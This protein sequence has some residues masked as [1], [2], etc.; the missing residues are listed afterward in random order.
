MLNTSTGMALGDS[1]DAYGRHWERNIKKTLEDFENEKPVDIEIGDAT[2][3]EEIQYTISIFH[4][5]TNGLE[6]DEVCNTF[7]ALPCDDWDSEIYGVSTNQAEWLKNQGFEVKE[8]WNSYNGE[9]SLSQVIQ[10]TYVKR[11]TDLYV[12]LQVHQGCDIRGGYT[13][14]KMFY[15]PEGYMPSENVIGD[16]DGAMIDNMYNGTSLTGEGGESVPVNPDS[17]ISLELTEY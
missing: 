10:G 15:L 14:A 7:N 5:L 9:S 16:L 12:L 3:S 11:D 17:V 4:Y 2:T 8:S 6:L 1:G 13:D